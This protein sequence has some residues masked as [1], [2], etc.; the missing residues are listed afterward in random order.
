MDQILSNYHRMF[1]NYPDVIN[2]QQM[3]EMLGGICTK[4]AYKLLKTNAINHF[5]IGKTYK[6]PKA[7][8]ITYLYRVMTASSISRCDALVH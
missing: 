2:V 6:I 8:V 7:D 3:C 4:T 5:R 1:R